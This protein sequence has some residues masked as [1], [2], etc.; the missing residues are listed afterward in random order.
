MRLC[1]GIC[2]VV[3][4]ILQ[5]YLCKSKKTWVGMILPVLTFGTS[6]YFNVEE[7]EAAFEN[8]FSLVMLLLALLSLLACN[9]PTV[10]FLLIY[11][12]KRKLIDLKSN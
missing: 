5:Y 2:I 7:L 11:K 1:F 12:R 8:G 3:L 9:M 10:L 4:S 6:I